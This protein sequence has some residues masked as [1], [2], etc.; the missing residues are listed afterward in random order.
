MCIRDRY[1]KGTINGLCNLAQLKA[2][3]WGPSHEV[4]PV[5]YTHLDVYKRQLLCATPVLAEDMRLN[6]EGEVYK[7]EPVSY[8]HLDVYKRQP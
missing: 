2:D 4:G 3:S 8:T 5:S 1:S 7:I 6:N